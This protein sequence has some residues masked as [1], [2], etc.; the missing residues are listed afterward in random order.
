[1]VRIQA[2]QSNGQWHQMAVVANNPS[3]IKRELE[4]AANSSVAQ[5]TRKP[6]AIDAETGNLIDLY[7]A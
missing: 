1:M 4:K 3:T 2:L 6:R 7:Q 5:S